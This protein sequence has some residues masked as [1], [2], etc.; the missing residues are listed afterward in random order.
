MC[1]MPVSST[2]GIVRDPPSS[3]PAPADLGAA[4][5]RAIAVRHLSRRTEQAYRG[6]IRR[7]LSHHGRRHPLELGKE[8]IEEFLSS[9]AT[10]RGLSASAQNQALSALI[11]LYRSV[12]GREFPWLADLVRARRPSRLPVVLSRRE[13][14]RVLDRLTGVPRL[15]AEV[16]YGGGLRLMECARLRV[17]QID[18]GRR[19]ILV[20]DGKGRK[21]RQTILPARVVVP[22]AR[23]LDRVRR[24]HEKEL[25][26]GRGA[27][28]LP[29]ALERKYPN[30]AK[31]WRLSRARDN[32]HYPACRVIPRQG[33]ART[34]SRLLVFERRVADA[35]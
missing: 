21:D 24:L 10:E 23:H 33:T 11:F 13:V 7:F 14:A 8:E 34:R 18:F 12:Y 9:L 32:R 15:M 20:R 6:W 2:W 25:R 16:M 26:T 22:L 5:R 1:A 30:A 28:A 29:D 31:E 3:E 17:Q 19:E 4:I 35:G 27:V